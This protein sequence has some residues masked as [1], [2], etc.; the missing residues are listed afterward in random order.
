MKSPPSGADSRMVTARQPAC[1]SAPGCGSWPRPLPLRTSSGLLPWSAQS[2]CLKAHRAGPCAAEFAAFW[3]RAQAAR[4]RPGRR[5]GVCAFSAS[6]AAVAARA[7]VFR[8]RSWAPAER[9]K[10]VPVA[11]RAAGRRAVRR[12]RAVRGLRADPGLAEVA[13]PAAGVACV[14]IPRPPPNP[15]SV[16]SAAARCAGS[17]QAEAGA[18]RGPPAE[19]RAPCAPRRPECCGRSPACLP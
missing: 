2:Q 6:A 1:A 11:A 12:Q 17:Q 19:D 7:E 15:V 3:Q 16:L 13:G 4:F 18:R 10:P 14:A 5:A 8:G 9:E